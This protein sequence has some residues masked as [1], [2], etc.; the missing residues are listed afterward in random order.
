M[1]DVTPYLFADEDPWL[2]DED[3]DLVKTLYAEKYNVAA[4]LRPRS[5]MEIGVRAG[6]S[7]AAFLSACPEASYLGIDNDSGDYGAWQG[8]PMRA[9]AMLKRHWPQAE[10]IDLDSQ[11]LHQLPAAD[12]VHVDGCHSYA[13]CLYDLR[14]AG[15]AARYILVDDVDHHPRSVG[16]AVQDFL[17][18]TGFRSVYLPSVRGD[19]LIACVD[20]KMFFSGGDVGDTLYALSVMKQLGGGRLRLYHAD[21]V[22]APFDAAKV[23]R[24]R[25]LLE[26]QPY[27]KEVSFGPRVGINLDAWRSHYKGNLN[28]ADMAADAHQLPPIGRNEPWLFCEEPNAVAP[29]VMHRSQR[30]HGFFDW[31][32]L[33]EKYRKQAVFIGQPWE[34]EEFC[35]TFGEVPYYHTPDWWEAARVI[36][37]C[38]IFCGNQS[39]PMALALGLCKTKIVQERHPFCANCHFEREGCYYGGFNVNEPP[40]LP[41]VV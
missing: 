17:A 37:G 38:Q 26:R 34:H 23:E 1:F 21:Y 2:K 16:R 14:L 8:A 22:R 6:Y 31:T 10:V 29:V 9:A 18:E 35:K 36:S 41:E 27:I 39:G 20:L 30:Y 25:P 4:L 13:G 24:L 12:L 40:F 5:I 19:V 33:A 15:K 7:A 28:I 3:K 32:P 11:Q